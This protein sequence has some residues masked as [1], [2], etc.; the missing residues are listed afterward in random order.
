MLKKMRRSA[1]VAAAT[2]ALALAVVPATPA[3]AQDCK[4]M[5]GGNY[6]SEVV[7]CVYFILITTIDDPDLPPHV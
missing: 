1:A 7:D 4:I 6:I 3:V 5:G 2:A